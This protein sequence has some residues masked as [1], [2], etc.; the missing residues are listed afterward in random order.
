MGKGELGWTAER[1]AKSSGQGRK[2][3]MIHA[4]TKLETSERMTK[5]ANS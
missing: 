3:M 1:A 4:W 2:V 5:W